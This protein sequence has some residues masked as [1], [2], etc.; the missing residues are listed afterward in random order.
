MSTE[1]DASTTNPPL[2]IHRVPMTSGRVKIPLRGSKIPVRFE[3][4]AS[5]KEI[6]R[7]K[8]FNPLNPWTWRIWSK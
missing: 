4:V 5:H 6:K 7:R 8:F 1:T 2:Y 3:T